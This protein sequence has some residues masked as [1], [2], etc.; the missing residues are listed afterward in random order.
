MRCTIAAE[1]TPGSVAILGIGAVLS[2]KESKPWAA[3]YRG[4]AVAVRRPATTPA[5]TSPL[6][7]AMSR[8][9]TSHDGH[10]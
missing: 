9:R 1:E 5:R 7:R 8:L 2:T 3:R 10:R 6:I 4:N